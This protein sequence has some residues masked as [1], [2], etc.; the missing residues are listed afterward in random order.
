MLS[1][2]KVSC[3]DFTQ[4]LTHFKIAMENTKNSPDTTRSNS[5]MLSNTQHGCVFLALNA[6]SHPLCR[7]LSASVEQSLLIN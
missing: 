2:G 6:L 1:K 7:I 3:I 5:F 4:L